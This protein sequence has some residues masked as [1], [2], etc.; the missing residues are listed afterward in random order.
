[1]SF[2][3]TD[4][5]DFEKDCKVQLKV[6]DSTIAEVFAKPRAGTIPEIAS[7]EAKFIASPSDRKLKIYIHEFNLGGGAC[8]HKLKIYDGD[9][10]QNDPKV[11]V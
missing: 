9:P 7:C 11:T 3:V 8:G 6:Y 10:H 5:I 4:T 2:S 1:M